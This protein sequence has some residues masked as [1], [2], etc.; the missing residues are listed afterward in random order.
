VLAVAVVE[1]VSLPG[2]GSR[3]SAVTVAVL[4]MVPASVA[5]TRRV[6][7]CL[8]WPAR[9]P[10]MQVTTSGVPPL[11][12]QPLGRG[13]EGNTPNGRV[14]VTVTPV[15]LVFPLFVTSMV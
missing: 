12:V 11:A 14:S 4:V 9:V 3:W 5:T 13:P 10:T 7:V 2:L 6:I 15:A 1:D 8:E